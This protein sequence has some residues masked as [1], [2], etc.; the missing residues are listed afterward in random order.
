MNKYKKQILEIHKQSGGFTL[1]ELLTVLAIIGIISVISMP[2]YRQIRP[3]ISLNSETRDIVSN[4]RYTQQL[5]VTEQVN[6]SVAFDSLLNKYTI[7]N[8][9]TSEIIKDETINSGITI[10]SISGFTNNAVIFNVTGAALESG[11]IILINSNS[12]TTTISIKPSGY[13]KIE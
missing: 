9:D 8:T 12:V 2:I 10:D 4:L 5:A 13:V 1:L 3:T 6:Y 7:T 11:T